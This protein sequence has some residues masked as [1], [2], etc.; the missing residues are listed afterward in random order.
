MEKKVY[1]VWVLK[2]N[3]IGKDYETIDAGSAAEAKVLIQAK[4]WKVCKIVNPA[5]PQYWKK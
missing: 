5:K 1:G 2:P 4:G 3:R